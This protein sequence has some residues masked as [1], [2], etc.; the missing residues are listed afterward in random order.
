[1]LLAQGHIPEAAKAYA[2]IPIVLNY[3]EERSSIRKTGKIAQA[4]EF[5]ARGDWAS[6]EQALN[7]VLTFAPDAKLSSDWALARLRLFTL[8]NQPDKAEIWAKRLLPVINDS[9]RSVLLYQLAELLQA[10]HKDNDLATKAIQ[11]LNKRFPYSEES[12]KARAK[13]PDV[14]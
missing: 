8:E 5:M 7:E 10:S 1:L 9:D 2:K 6:A 13:W 11:E 12:A 14:K 3:G 4:N